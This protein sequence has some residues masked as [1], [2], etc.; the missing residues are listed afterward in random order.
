MWQRSKMEIQQME[1]SRDTRFKDK[2]QRHIAKNNWKE[3]CFVVMDQ[4]CHLT[5]LKVLK[6][7]GV[8][9]NGQNQRALIT[10]SVT[11]TKSRNYWNVLVSDHFNA[12]NKAGLHSPKPGCFQSSAPGNILWHRDLCA[13]ILLGSILWIQVCGGMKGI[14]LRRG[15]SCT[16]DPI[17]SQR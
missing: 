15:K 14:V 8:I 16:L 7:R 5:R 9:G 1:W 10:V 13:G 17:P 2:D 12:R 6:G 11:P 3:L 4:W